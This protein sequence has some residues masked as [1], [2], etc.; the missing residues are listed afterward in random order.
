MNELHELNRTVPE[1]PDKRKPNDI[2]VL[3]YHLK[4]NRYQTE[5]LIDSEIFEMTDRKK[6]AR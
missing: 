5:R 1:T 6:E 3:A 2:E 4:L